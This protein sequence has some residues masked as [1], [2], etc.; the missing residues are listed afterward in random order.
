[1]KL[2]RSRLSIVVY[3]V[4]FSILFSLLPFLTHSYLSFSFFLSSCFSIAVREIC[5][6]FPPVSDGRCIDQLDG[7]RCVCQSGFTGPEC[8]RNVDDCAG[9][10]CGEHGYCV[11]LVNDYRCQC[12]AG[13]VGSLCQEDVDDCDMRPCANG[14]RCTDLPN[15][16]Q[17]DCAPGFEGKDC[18]LMI[19]ECRGSPCLHGGICQDQLADY[20]CS[21]PE[22]FWGKNCEKYEGMPIDPDNNHNKGVDGIKNTT[23]TARPPASP[24]TVGNGDLSGQM[25]SSTGDQD[26][27]ENGLNMTQLLV[28][29]CLGVGI[30]L[31]LIIIAVTILLCRKRSYLQQRHTQ[32]NLENMAREKERHYINNMNNKSST[33]VSSNLSSPTSDANIFTTLPNSASNSS[34]IKIS[35]EEQQD[36]NKLKAKHLMLAGD[37]GL[38]S[39]YSSDMETPA[40][41]PTG[42]GGGSTLNQHMSGTGPQQRNPNTACP[43]GYL[44]DVV[45]ITHKELR[46]QTPSPPSSSSSS[47]LPSSSSAC[48]AT[49]GA[50]RGSDCN[51]DFEKTYRRLDVDSLQADTKRPLR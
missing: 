5:L 45:A 41:T 30:P 8:Q 33:T 23:F 43:S 39:S 42:G 35:N 7:Y 51:L 18:S 24:T 32:Q 10:P 37:C 38:T 13:F 36:I 17:C 34:S 2:Q 20:T 50:R 22:G 46:L 11:D 9:N 27:G 1:M 21:C 15:D 28:I 44:R 47:V 12:Q 31:I 29:V 16:F 4:A 3:T 48:P 26:D 19:D 40:S 14:G 6:I 49:K 25:D